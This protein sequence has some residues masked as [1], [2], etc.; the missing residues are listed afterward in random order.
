MPRLREEPVL[1]RQSPEQDRT[2]GKIDLLQA[3]IR[4]I[5]QKPFFLFFQELD[6][7]FLLRSDENR[8]LKQSHL[9]PRKLK[10]RSRRLQRQP[11]IPA[12]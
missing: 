11:A 9:L 5:L 4:E 8:F 2:T 3:L 7:C 1:L 6:G 10:R 12:L